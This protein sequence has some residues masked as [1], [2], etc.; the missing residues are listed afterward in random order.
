M[1]KIINTN[2]PEGPEILKYSLF[3]KNLC[4]NK[5]I[6]SMHGN[7]AKIKNNIGELKLPLIVNNVWS[8]GK[9]II[10]ELYD[11]KENN[12]YYMTS[13]LGMKGK[14][15]DKYIKYTNL[16][17]SFGELVENVGKYQKT[18][19]IYYAD[20][21]KYGTICLLKDLN[22]VFKRHG[23]CLM[24]ASLIRNNHMSMD[25]L[26]VIQIENI[27]DICKYKDEIRNK[28][29][30]KDKRLAEFMMEQNRVSGVGNYLRA[31]ILYRS[32]LSPMRLLSTLSDDE[33]KML[34]EE[35]LTNMY[36][37]FKDGDLYHLNMKVYKKE[38]DPAGNVIE[39]FK[40]KNKRMCYFVK[41]IQK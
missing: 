25:K 39:T 32:K 30:R 20:Q 8:H 24:T 38:K 31:E 13:Q 10:F 37:S 27:C 14:W 40:D 18:F 23:P 34:Y 29:F 19:S 15:S 21:L 33:I 11:E 2:M 1:Q 4:L 26:N 17:I 35:T 41:E 6:I 12:N 5:T 7:G 3:L 22:D 9:V 28:S 16:I 36:E